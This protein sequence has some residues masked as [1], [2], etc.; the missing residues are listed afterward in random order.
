MTLVT[1]PKGAVHVSER[2]PLGKI[3][4]KT[5]AYIACTV[6]MLVIYKK[7]QVLLSNHP[8]YHSSKINNFNIKAF[9]STTILTT[10]MYGVVMHV[11]SNH[12]VLISCSK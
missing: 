1:Y 4:I 8:S 7:H 12:Y 3:T 6:P 11:R 9:D 10:Y 5:L 2:P